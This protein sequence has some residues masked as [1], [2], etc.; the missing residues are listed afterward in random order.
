[1]DELQTVR[2]FPRCAL[3]KLPHGDPDEDGLRLALLAAL[4]VLPL[5]VLQRFIE[6]IRRPKF[7]VRGPLID[8]KQ[9]LGAVCNGNLGLQPMPKWADHCLEISPNNKL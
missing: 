1:M 4:L 7:A 6:A 8:K 9:M 3:V 2:H 5:S